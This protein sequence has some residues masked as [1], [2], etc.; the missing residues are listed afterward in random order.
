MKGKI[1]AGICL[2]AGVLSMS[3]NIEVKVAKDCGISTLD[4]YYAPIE[5]YAN[6]K[7]R[8]ERGVVSEN[9]SLTDGK[10]TINIP[11]AAA[12][13]M[14]VFPIEGDNISLYVAPG[15][16]VNLD[17]DGCKPLVYTMSGTDLV[18]GINTLHQQ[19]LPIMEKVAALNK[20]GQSNSEEMEALAEQ[21]YDLQR[22][23]IKNNSGSA[24]APVAL[25]NL[26][27]EEFINTY[28][29]LQA[30]MDKS[31]LS[32]ILKNQYQREKKGMEMAKKQQAMEQGHM[33]APAFTL[34]DLEGKD[35]SLSDFR[36]KWVIL[37]FWGSWCPWCI[38]GFPE[39]KEAYAKYAGKLE[40]IGIDCNEGEA[41]WRAGVEKYDLPW[42]NLYNP[43]DTTVTSDYGVQGF[44]T[45]VIINPE[46]Q[47]CLIAV[48]HD[49][50]FF[51]KLAAL[52]GE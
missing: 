2:M 36:G 35:V 22:N 1:L 8:A 48:G 37:D 13:Y 11:T 43:A 39:L 38:K 15:E 4:Y 16:N 51:N 6:A 32:P 46:G 18:D 7:T 14:Y 9:L 42:V 41:E 20:S 30:L 28:E 27:G 52:M 25:L 45:K 29:N 33:E 12:G 26:E 34:K 17:I 50:N 44:P 10:G 31:I 47:V 49:P 3:A 21:Y 40:I 24:A 23:Y 5:Q 19:E